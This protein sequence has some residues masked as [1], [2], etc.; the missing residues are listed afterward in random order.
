ME[1]LMHLM[2]QAVLAA[3]ATALLLI[4]LF[5]KQKKV[6]WILS[7]LALVATLVVNIQ[8]IIQPLAPLALTGADAIISR[9]AVNDGFSLYF[10]AVF[11]AFGILTLLLAED[12]LEKQN[13]IRGEFYNVVL[14]SIVGLMFIGAAWD[15]V[16]VFLGL[17]ILSVGL[18]ILAGINKR[19]FKSKEAALKYFLL[20]AFSTGFLLY[21][22]ALIYG[23]HGTTNMRD[24]LAL[25]SRVDFSNILAPA[26]KEQ[27]T[28]NLFMLGG[29]ILLIIGF[30]FKVSLVPFH[31]WTPDVYEGA[32][33][34]VTGF[35]AAAPKAGGFAAVL[36][37]FF[38]IY[39]PQ[40][41]PFLS[42]FAVLA[43]LT[44]ITG[45]LLAI[46]QT[47]IKRMLA[48]SSI[49]HIG[50]L[51]LG[52]SAGTKDAASA[53][54]FYTLIYGLMNLGA[55]AVIAHITKY[56]EEKATLDGIKGLAHS[57]PYIAIALA[58]FMF[59]LAGIPPTA[60]F[61]GKFYVFMALVGS[62]NYALAV[63]GVL[64]SGLALYYYL[65]VVVH[66]YMK[67]DTEP[68]QFESFGAAT[69][70]AVMLAVVGVLFL[71]IVP[72]NVYDVVS[73]AFTI[74]AR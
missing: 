50:Y 46:V 21:G 64:N 66:L 2:P 67:G 56:D 10:N 40:A 9:M 51:F 12:Y 34:P 59:A 57:R 8:L 45:N 23:A 5:V 72:G 65:N 39:G 27:F 41:T 32:P 15:L 68:A 16:V 63:I 33:S 14:W 42:L 43:V 1:L 53:I 31:M 74:F 37:I 30:A 70:V 19:S 3:A 6:T 48:F 17:E 28:Q 60:G 44:L 73:N 25:S 62:G 26:A 49:T 4:D 52:L 18:Y 29:G 71:G 69:H 61:T 55:F 11:L 38:A 20:G 58:L 7:I 36:K 35:M 13:I 47:N 22:I 24:L 54:M